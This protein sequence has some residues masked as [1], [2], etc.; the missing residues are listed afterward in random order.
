MALVHTF[1]LVERL[2]AIAYTRCYVP[3]LFDY[4]FFKNNYMNLVKEHKGVKIFVSIQGEFYCDANT[5]SNDY[6]NKTF[7]STKLQSVEKAIDDFKGQEIDGNRY[8]DIAVYNTTFIPLRVVRR[9]GS[10]L[11]FDDGT[12]TSSHSRRNL[13]PKSIDEKQEFKDL[14]LLFD[15][16]KENQKEINNLYK[17]QKQLRAEADKKLRLMS[18]VGVS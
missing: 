6:K 1:K 5:N 16:L 8:Y 9:V 18:K 11:F 15:K 14:E 3:F 2:C 10:R 7:V 17:I 4:Q 12:D 13:Y